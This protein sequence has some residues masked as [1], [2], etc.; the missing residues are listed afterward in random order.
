MAF[1]RVERVALLVLVLA[2]GASPTPEPVALETLTPETVAVGDLVSERAVAAFRLDLEPLR[3]AGLHPLRRAVEDRLADLNDDV[4]AVLPSIGRV[5]FELF[6]DEHDR[7]RTGVAVLQTQ[8]SPVHVDQAVRGALREPRV[9]RDGVHRGRLRTLV[10]I[11]PDHY[12]FGDITDVE[13][14]GFAAG[15]TV[16]WNREPA[17]MGWCR[18]THLTNTLFEAVIGE[19]ES[20]RAELEVHVSDGTAHLVLDLESD[21]PR[22]LHRHA[23][24][25][26]EELRQTLAIVSL[27][28]DTPV[29]DAVRIEA[30]DR[31]IRWTTTMPA[32]DLAR[33]WEH[34]AHAFVMAR[35]AR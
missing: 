9:S 32:P 20:E 6:E 25:A 29:L 24:V 8:W 1:E 7:I 17:V 5:Q 2:C 22:V 31:G 16:V 13:T 23:M 28:L 21:Q 26:L 15:P 18:R 11:D 3:A 35:Y 30:V 33:V 27:V 19:G 12:L 14:L 4:A 10:A 34:I